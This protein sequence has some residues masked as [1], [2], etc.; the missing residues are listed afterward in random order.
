MKKTGI[1]AAVL[2]FVVGMFL[3]AG[4]DLVDS[5]KDQVIVIGN[6]PFDYEIPKIEVARAVAIEK[7]YKVE[8]LAGDIAFMFLA[9]VE[10][11]TDIWPGIWLPSIHATYH[12]EYGEQYELSNPIYKD[13]PLGWVVPK[14]VDAD[15]IADLVGNEDAVG[16]R[17]V[18]FD[19]GS[20]MM[21]VSQEIIDGYGLDLELVPG[22]YSTMMAEADEAMRNN[23]P[24]L[25]LGWR[26]DVMF[27]NY[28]IKL[29]D[30]PLG[31]WVYDSAYWA[32]GLGFKEKAPDM[33]KFIKNFEMSIEDIEAFLFAIEE[34]RDAEELA[35][36]WIEDNRAL[37]DSWFE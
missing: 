6:A 2:F 20:G 30:D 15:S 28:D 22:S 16:G 4:C 25:F 27:R 18:G 13:A 11:D 32:I 29:L 17:L 7:G 19:P 5:D 3:V 31:Y 36:E 23:E 8:I 1:V 26:P 33:Y 10:G 9:I 21:L 12:Q 24:V 37:V 35:R 34:G 14:Y